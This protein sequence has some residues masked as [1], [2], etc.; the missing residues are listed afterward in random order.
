MNVNAGLQASRKST[1]LRQTGYNPSLAPVITKTDSKGKQLYYGLTKS[2]SKENHGLL[3]PVRISKSHYEGT[4]QAFN[5]G[6]LVR[7]P[8]P[9]K[10]NIHSKLRESLRRNGMRITETAA[11]S[12]INH[13]MR[14]SGSFITQ[15]INTAKSPGKNTVNNEHVRIAKGKAP[16]SKVSGKAYLTH[17]QKASRKAV[18]TESRENNLP[19]YKRKESK[20]QIL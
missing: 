2:T 13:C 15:V 19:K 18:A 16:N 17:K 8:S 3:V 4:V 10:S 20:N 9:L 1:L 11:K 5:N 14:T 6:T 12:V 7:A